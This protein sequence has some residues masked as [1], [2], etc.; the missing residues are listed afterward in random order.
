[1]T[2]DIYKYQNELGNISQEIKT[3][4][5][6]L[7]DICSNLEINLADPHITEKQETALW[8]VER[9]VGKAISGLGD[10]EMY[11]ENLYED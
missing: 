4:M 3:L 10:V 6:K 5:S 9:G 8:R 7:K 11:L 2:I 1:M